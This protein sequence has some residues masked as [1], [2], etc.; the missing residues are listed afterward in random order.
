MLLELKNVS[1]KYGDYVA[2]NHISL[3]IPRG[4]IVGLLGPNGAGKTTLIR[5]ITRINFPDE[6]ELLFDGK[7]L[8]EKDTEHIGYMPEERGLYKAMTVWDQLIYLARLKN[9][10]K[11]DAINKLNF[12]LEKLAVDSWK[13]KKIEELSK[14][15]AQKV[16]FIAT[17]LHDPELLIL[18]EPFS[19]LDPINAKV[20]E[21]EIH[22][23]KNKGKTIIFSTHRMEQVEDICEH[24]ILINKG[25]KLL[26]GKIKEVKSTYKEGCYTI[27]ISNAAQDFS[28]AP[29]AIEMISAQKMRIR[30]AADSN[31]ILTYFIGKNCGILAFEEELPTLNQI[32]IKAVNQSPINTTIHE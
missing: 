30:N 7:K 24:I 15:M 2:S 29:F 3:A 16:Q 13:N 21:D 11:P 23:L 4:E 31:T 17:I 25:N 1:K 27:A 6:G 9:I 28:D 12:W 22:E 14:G 20:I 32:F 18:D 5:M 10:S 8:S 19:G 26:D